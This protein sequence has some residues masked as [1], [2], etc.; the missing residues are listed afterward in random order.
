MY[1]EVQKIFTDNATIITTIPQFNDF[2]AQ[3]SAKVLAIQTKQLQQE[4]DIKRF[5]IHK[6]E[7]RIALINKVLAVSR[8]LLTFAVA[9]SDSLLLPLVDFTNPD[10]TRNSEK[11]LNLT[12]NTVVEQATAKLAQL[13]TY[14]VTQ[15]MIDDISD[16]LSA[17]IDVINDLE[18]PEGERLLR[19]ALPMARNIHA[20]KERARRAGIPVVYVNDNFGRWQSNFHAQVKHCLD[21]PCRS[22][23]LPVVGNTL[24][25]PDMR[26]HLHHS[27]QTAMNALGY[28]YFLNSFK[29]TQSPGARSYF[30]AYQPTTPC[31]VIA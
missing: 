11:Y 8:K 22:E 5:A 18:F 6:E 19:H 24:L 23:N 20:L 30:Q 15:Q 31:F 1:T 3:F 4:E 13:A 10:L 9:T 26:F 17:F 14:N 29:N 21:H 16:A 12:A 2:L 7:L 28:I 25:G 27:P